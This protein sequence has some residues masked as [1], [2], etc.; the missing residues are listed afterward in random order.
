M[1]S[2]TSTLKLGG[3]TRLVEGMADEAQQVC[4]RTALS[5]EHD[6]K[7]DA[8]VDTGF[9]RRSIYSVTSTGSDYTSEGDSL[10]QVDRPAGISAAV[11]VASPY[12]W[13]VNFGTHRMAGRPYF[14]G[15][16]ERHRERFKD[17]LKKAVEG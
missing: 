6:A 16:V 11:G 7:Q 13:W 17:E 8:P 9:L 14:S 3:L 4:D 1:F 2:L 15:A 5:I 10:P 12:G